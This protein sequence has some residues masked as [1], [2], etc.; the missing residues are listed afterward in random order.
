MQGLGGLERGWFMRRWRRRSC[1]GKQGRGSGA[2]G[3]GDYCDAEG[4]AFV[5]VGVGLGEGVGGGEVGGGLDTGVVVLRYFD[6]L[7]VDVPVAGRCSCRRGGQR[8]RMKRVLGL[9]SRCFSCISTTH[10][11]QAVSW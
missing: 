6:G 3:C 4:E 1:K 2:G 10:S 5:G 9:P 8:E 7:V 11:F